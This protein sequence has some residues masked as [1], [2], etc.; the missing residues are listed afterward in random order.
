[1]K[2]EQALELASKHVHG[3]ILCGSEHVS[4]I[5]CFLPAPEQLYPTN[6]RQVAFYGI[7]QKCL[8]DRN[9]QQRI[10]AKLME[11]RSRK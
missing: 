2:L 4:Y 7:C 11:L 9:A 10:E 6:K 1:L 8:K 3:C 5:G